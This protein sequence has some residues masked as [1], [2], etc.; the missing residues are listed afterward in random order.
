MWIVFKKELYRVFSDKKL[1]FT[2]FFLSPLI[3]IAMFG[4]MLGIAAFTANKVD[5][6]IPTVLI[7]NA[8]SFIESTKGIDIEFSNGKDLNDIAALVKE[9]KYDL[10]LDFDADFE[11]AVRS[12]RVPKYR[13]FGDLSDDYKEAA[14]KRIQERYL[15]P[16]RHTTLVSL[17]GGEEQLKVFESED[18]SYEYKITEAKFTQ[19][20]MIAKFAP[21]MIFI[22]IIGSAMGLVMES[23]AGEKERGTLATQL[24]S[25]MPRERFALGKLFG[26]SFH[27][28]TATVVSVLSFF[29]LMLAI[30]TFIPKDLFVI[31]VI[32]TYKE[33]LLM[34][35]VLVPSLL[36]NT[37]VLMTLSS[38]G[39]NLKESSNY[40]MPFYMAT[41]FLT[42]IPMQLPAG[43]A[44]A[45]WMYLVPILGQ[46]CALTDILGFNVQLLNIM[47][48]I[49]VPLLV[50]M[51]M[52]FIVRMIF[53]NEKYIVGE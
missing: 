1:L 25:P 9:G 24:L 12:G 20:R 42:M 29:L 4:V 31:E 49:V 44:F 27:A 53:N 34:M 14:Y 38:L 36:M 6:N 11:D 48:A 17:V 7:N 41:I 28:A 30:S 22:I 2:T 32:Y 50:A 39:R 10:A 8:P 43:E 40:V 46:V 16:Y 35:A 5:S 13:Y 18:M 33:A 21:Y 26:L 47:L 19:G 51:T 3:M 23:V 15:E 52:V 45:W 37:S